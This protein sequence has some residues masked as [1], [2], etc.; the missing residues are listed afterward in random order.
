MDAFVTSRGL[1]FVSYIY[2]F[3]IVPL[4]SRPCNNEELYKGFF[5]SNYTV[6]IYKGLFPA[7][8]DD[9]TYVPFMSRSGMHALVCVGLITPVLRM[10]WTSAGALR[11]KVCTV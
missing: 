4:N 5:Y 10:P 7:T 8:D 11:E 3:S 6:V 9:P 1:R 2:G